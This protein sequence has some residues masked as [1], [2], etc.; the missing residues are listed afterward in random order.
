MSVNIATVSIVT[1][2]I[3]VFLFKNHKSEKK[4]SAIF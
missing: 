4:W 2:K 3:S 1:V